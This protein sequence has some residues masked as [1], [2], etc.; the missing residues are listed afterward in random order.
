MIRLALLA[1][2]L[3]FL[4]SHVHAAGSIE[5]GKKKSTTCAACHA[6]DGNSTTA[7]FPR[8]AGQHADYIAKALRDY[9]SGARK[10]PVMAGFAAPL[11]SQDRADLAAYFA[12]QKGL[13]TSR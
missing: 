5:D 9:K 8:L 3:M 1:T 6:A 4:S 7:E 10:D 11:T 13:A 12:S 2:G